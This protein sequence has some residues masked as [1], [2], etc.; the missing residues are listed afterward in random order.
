VQRHKGETMKKR[1]R[2]NNVHPLLHKEIVALRLPKW[3]T[4]W[5][6]EQPE[7]ST[8]LI[9][10]AMKIAYKLEAPDTTPVSVVSGKG[11]KKKAR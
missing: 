3:M 11:M 7:T 2:R 5:M 9:E 1:K 8:V 10:H 4:E 6:A